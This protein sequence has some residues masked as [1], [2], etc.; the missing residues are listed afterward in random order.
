MGECNGHFSCR[1]KCVV[2]SRG[3]LAEERGW[4]PGLGSNAFCHSK[5]AHQ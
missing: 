4:D 5:D 2:E 1:L 3:S